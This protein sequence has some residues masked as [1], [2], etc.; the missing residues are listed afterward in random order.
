M[1]MPAA[2]PM[3]TAKAKPPAVVTNVCQELSR[4]D[5]RHCH[6]DA[7]M[8]DGVGRTNCSI[9]KARTA[10]SHTTKTAMTTTHGRMCRSVFRRSRKGL[11][12]L[13][14]GASRRVVR[15]EEHTSELQSQSNLVCRLL[16]VKKKKHTHYEYQ[17]LHSNLSHLCHHLD[18]AQQSH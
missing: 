2:S 14:G 1:A 9:W 16:L 3:I 17:M 18:T 4:M 13:T 8:A 5:Q 11:R 7:K 12:G 10:S 15:S 6:P